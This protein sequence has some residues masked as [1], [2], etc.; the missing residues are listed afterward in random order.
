MYGTTVHKTHTGWYISSLISSGFFHVHLFYFL[1]PNP[2]H[3]SSC[4]ISSF[5]F[6]FQPHFLCVIGKIFMWNHRICGSNCPG[7]QQ[8]C[9]FKV[10]MQERRGPSS[11][12]EPCELES[13]HIQADNK[14][15]AKSVKSQSMLF[16][17]NFG[18][19]K[20]VAGEACFSCFTPRNRSLSS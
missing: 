3:L 6:K 16:R 8:M 11:L 14:P 2:K 5:N 4:I 1:P 20:W 13:A 15:R 19:F 18:D 17:G 9:C 12:H 7:S 10:L